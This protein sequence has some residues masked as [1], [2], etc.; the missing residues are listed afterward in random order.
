MLPLTRIALVLAAMAFAPYSIGAQ[1]DA[2]QDAV[3]C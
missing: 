1:S 3:S 2:Y